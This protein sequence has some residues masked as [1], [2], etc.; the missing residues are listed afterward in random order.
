ML[1][2]QRL[3]SLDLIDSDLQL[4]L[5]HPL[6]KLT[7]RCRWCMNGYQHIQWL[8]WAKAISIPFTCTSTS[9]VA[10]IEWKPFMEALDLRKANSTGLI[11]LPTAAHLLPTL[12]HA[13]LCSPIHTDYWAAENW[14]FP[15]TGLALAP[16]L[17]E[18]PNDTFATFSHCCTPAVSPQD[19][20]LNWA[21]TPWVTAATWPCRIQNDHLSRGSFVTTIRL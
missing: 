16:G 15:S 5:V 2:L 7:L 10:D 18:V 9:S 21:K 3:L 8:P 6:G 12:H 11:C 17:A 14:C 13:L 19:W 20:A 1:P 4:Q